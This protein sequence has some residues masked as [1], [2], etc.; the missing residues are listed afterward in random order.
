MTRQIG[1]RTVWLAA[2]FAA[3]AF[4]STASAQVFTGR[5]DV[6]IEDST[7]GRLPGV[8][9]DLTGPVNQTQV[10]DAQGPGAFPEP[11]GRHLRHESR[12]IAGFNHLLEQHGAGGQRRQ[13]AAVGQARRRRNLGDDQRHRGDAAHRPQARHDDDQRAIEE[14]QNIPS[15]A[16][17]V[18]RACRRCPASSSIASTSAAP[19]RASSPTTRPR[20]RSDRRQHLEHRRHPDHRHGARPARRRPTTTSTCSRRCR[21]RPA[22]PTCSNPT[23]GVQLNMV[24]K[25]GTNTPHGSARI[26]FENEDLQANN[27]PD[28][29]RRRRSAAPPARATASTSTR[30]T[31]SSSAARSCK[32]RVWAWGAYGEDRRQPARRSTGDSDKTDAR[33]TTSLKVDGQ[34]DPGDPRQLHVLPAATSRSSAAA[35]ARRGRRRPTCNQTGPT[36]C[37]RVRPTSSSATACSCR[38]ASRTSTGGFQLA[39]QGGLRHGLV[40]R[41]RRRLRTTRSTSTRATR[42][43]D[44][45]GGDGNCFRGKHEVK[46]G[47]GWRIDAGRRPI[48]IW[49]ASHLICQLRR[50]SRTCSSQVAR[51]YQS[52]TDA[53]Y[54]E[55]VRRRHH[56]AGSADAQRRR[57]LRSPGVVARRR[58]GPGV[59]GIPD[60]L[61]ALNAPR[62]W[63][64]RSSGTTLTPR[65]GLDLRASDENRKTIARASYAMFASQLR[66][67]RGEVHLADPVI[68]YAYYNAVDHEQRRHRAD[69]RDPVQPG[70]AWLQRVR[71]DRPGASSTVNTVDPNM[72]AP[73]THELLFGVD[74]EIMPNFG[75]SATFTWRRMLGLLTGIPLT[76]VTLADYTPDRHADRERSAGRQPSRV[77]LYALRA[78]GDARRRRPDRGQPRGLPPALQGPRVQRRSSGCRTGGWRASASR[79]TTGASTST[80]R[81]SSIIDPTRRRRSPANAAASPARTSTAAW[82]VRQRPAAARATS[83]WS[84]PKYQFVANG[85]YQGPWGI[86]FGGNLVTRQGYAQPFFRSNVVTGDPLGRKDVLLVDDVDDFRLPAVTSLDARIEKK[87][88][89]GTARRSRWTS[90]SSTC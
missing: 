23:G 7:G 77:P 10:S 42:P 15:V 49:P 71:S 40:H 43:Q 44:D 88:T 53:K 1:K 4:A 17:S 27:M 58:H 83:T 61:P 85:L 37:T 56:V 36:Q 48:R 20:G 59:P 76:G 32:D 13:H 35:P 68:R 21:S 29:A 3:L 55:R 41:R 25:S 64:T 11:A 22:A 28:G 70:A 34:V 52:S 82:S 38:R 14:L 5:I 19:S 26:Y 62:R 46:F 31:A 45:I 87:F 65:V 69:R 63:R 8:N 79:P 57:P 72:K 24:L 6:T 80:I 54:T 78:D 16:R 90:T 30:T 50:L 67:R 51:D 39:P 73:L 75:V 9:V 12:A 74:R 33:R 47:G 66:R 18:G 89:F 84:L 81:R 86:N 60:L 2:L